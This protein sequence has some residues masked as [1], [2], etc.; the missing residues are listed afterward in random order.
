M[1]SAFGLV[2]DRELGSLKILL[3]SPIPRYSLIFCKMMAS[4]VVSILQVYAF[5]LVT[6]LYGI[7]F[8]VLIGFDPS[9]GLS[10]V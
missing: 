8:P 9:V 4:T 3:T 7:T 10:R 2:F 6:A 1:Q 5:L